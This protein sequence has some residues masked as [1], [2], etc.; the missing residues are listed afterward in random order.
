MGCP[1]YIFSENDCKQ[2]VKVKALPFI[3]EV[4]NLE[5]LGQ[6]ISFNIGA[7]KIE[8]R[9]VEKPD[10]LL[11]GVTVLV[12]FEENTIQTYNDRL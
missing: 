12:D 6:Y 7:L 10:W 2:S 11:N 8:V 4:S 5:F 1:T 9:G 3:G